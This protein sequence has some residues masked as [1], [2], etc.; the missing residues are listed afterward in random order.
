MNSKKVLGGGILLL[1]GLVFSAG[2]LM[3]SGIFAEEMIAS[4]KDNKEDPHARFRDGSMG[5][6]SGMSGMSGMMNPHASGS[7]KG[8]HHSK[9]GV[10]SP[11]SV[12]GLKERLGLDESQTKKIKAVISDYRK[13]SITK[14]A[15]LKIAQLEF[16][17]A[18]SEKGFSVSDVEKKAMKRESAATALTMVRVKALAGAREVLSDEQYSKFMGMMAHRMS[19][20]G[21]KGKHGGHGFGMHGKKSGHGGSLHG[22]M[23][24][25]GSF[26]G[27]GKGSMMDRHHGGG[28]PHGK[29]GKSGSEDYDE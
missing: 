12:M 17:E 4:S 14:K 24:G 3:P 13:G 29:M 20:H 11:F 10:H 1:A 18:V 19:R 2:V 28:S 6:M 22:A 23:K 16:D 21:G 27:H 25:H 9:K 15:E 26:G 7:K 5:G 8:G